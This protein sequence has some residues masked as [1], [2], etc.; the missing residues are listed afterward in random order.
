MRKLVVLSVLFF[1]SLNLFSIEFDLKPVTEKDVALLVYDLETG[2]EV[3]S[4]NP[5][6]ELHYASNLKLLTAATALHNL[7][8]GFRFLTLF[9]FDPENGTLYIKA[10][11]NP[12]MV[13]EKMWRLATDLKRKGVK[14]IK[15]VIVDDFL[16]GKKGYYQIPKAGKG[17]NAYLAPVSPLSL[18]YN[19]CEIFINP[20]TVGEKVNVEI[21]TPGEHFVINNTAVSVK[22][23]GNGLIVGTVPKGDKT[24]VIVKGT[25]GAGRKKPT[26]VY[27]KVWNPRDHYVSTLLHFLGNDKVDIKRQKLPSAFFYDK[28]RIKH[29]H[30]SSPLRDIL[31][32][33]NRYSSNYIADSIQFFMGAILKDGREQGVELL[34]SYASVQL[35]ETIDIVNG[36]GLG[37]AYNKLTARFFIKLLKKVYSNSYDSIDFFSTMPVMGEDGTLKS[38]SKNG[39]SVGFVRGK[40]GSLTGVAALSGIMKTKSGKIFL[41]SFAVN[42]YPSKRFKPMWNFRDK[43]MQKI[44]MEF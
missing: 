22:G 41:Y 42:N 21:A 6:K 3:V 8:G 19:S 24:E 39:T 18:N 25:L 20:T 15:K 36:S 26:I 23:G 11:G 12:E 32:I 13:V 17:D 35:G 4:I 37:N 43:I 7:G 1:C 40:T 27:K 16:Y 28:K 31:T 29:I 5:D 34:K 30:K 38:A 10:A 9:S 44:W 33:M 14:N 2:E